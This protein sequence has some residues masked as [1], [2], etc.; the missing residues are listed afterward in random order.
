MKVVLFCGGFGLRLGKSSETIPKPMLLI[1]YRP[2]LWHVMKYYAHFGHK[3]FILCLGWQANVIKQYFLNYD[4][5]ISNDFVFSNG[6]QKVELKSSDIHDWNITFVDTGMTANIGERLQAVQPY[7]AN[8][9]RFLANY[10]DGLHDLDLNQLLD[11]HEKR[12]STASFVSVRPT[13]SFHAV[14]TNGN[15]IVKEL[16]PITDSGIWMNAGCFVFE[17]SIFDYMEPG[18]ELV[19]EP[20]ERLAAQEKL[21]TYKHNGFFGCMDT[22]K[23]KQRLDE[24]YATGKAHWAVWEKLSPKSGIS[25]M[26]SNGIPFQ[27]GIPR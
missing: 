21:H 23:E 27:N 7:L 24:L 16:S 4:E 12:Q 1:G 15:G 18:E 26:S 25:S 8:E 6:G 19:A 9:E 10:T 22:L 13:Q 20:F 2:I 3:D 11:F 14:K 5:C 17:P